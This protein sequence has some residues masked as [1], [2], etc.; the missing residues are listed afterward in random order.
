[1]SQ[2]KVNS[3]VP[4]GGVSTGASGG[5]IQVIQKEIT[6]VGQI[7]MSNEQF[8][9]LGSNFSVAI[10]PSSTSSKILIMAMLNGEFSDLSFLYKAQM[11]FTRNG[12]EIWNGD[13]PDSKT[14]GYGPWSVNYHNDASN[15][16]EGKEFM[17]LDSP[18]TTSQVTYQMGIHC[19]NQSGTFYY[20]RNVSGTDSEARQRAVSTVIAMEVSPA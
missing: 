17:Y 18:N 4:T 8:N 14:P 3:I 6:T 10:T 16:M 2:L 20:N 11:A 5:I 13:N 1:M 12:T 15:T 19:G 9:S 7:S